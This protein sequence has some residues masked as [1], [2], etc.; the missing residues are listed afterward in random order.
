MIEL[1]QQIARQ[2]VTV[3]PRPAMHKL[4]PAFRPAMHNPATCD[5][6]TAACVFYAGAY[7]Q[8]AVVDVV[9]LWFA[10]PAPWQ[11]G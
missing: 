5:A 2:R 7:I 10:P 11:T 1:P 9:S 3:A 8:V 4:Q 6:Q